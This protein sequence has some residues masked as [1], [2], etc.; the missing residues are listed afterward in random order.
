MDFLI[1]IAFWF[2]VSVPVALLI[3]RLFITKFGDDE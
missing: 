3:V 2:A 1:M